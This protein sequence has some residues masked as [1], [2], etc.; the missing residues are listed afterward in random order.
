M[1]DQDQAKMDAEPDVAGIE[2]AEDERSQNEAIKV[3]TIC[4]I[5]IVAVWLGITVWDDKHRKK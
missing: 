3:G 1:A 4:I 2:K 5:L